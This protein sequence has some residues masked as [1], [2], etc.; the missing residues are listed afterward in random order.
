MTRAFRA[1]AGI[2]TG[3]VFVLLGIAALIDDGFSWQYV[4][5]T[6]LGVSFIGLYAYHLRQYR[7]AGRKRAPLIRPHF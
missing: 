4:A 1:K 7:A 3:I 2:A 5:C 6:L